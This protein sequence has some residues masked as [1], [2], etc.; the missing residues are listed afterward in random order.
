VVVAA[1]LGLAIVAAASFVVV[2]VV[3]GDTQAL[4]ATLGTALAALAA[5]LGVAGL[6]LVPHEQGEM[7][8]PA[9]DPA[10]PDET[11]EELELP[12]ERVPR[13]R[14]LTAATGA[15]GAAIGVAA[16]TPLASLGPRASASI[17]RSPW[18]RGR[19][20]VDEDGKPL[21]VHE[22]AA[23]DFVTAFP[24]GADPR[25]LGSPVVV[26]RVDPATLQLPAGRESWA[27]EGIL[28]FSKICTHAGCA[29]SLFRYPLYEP[30][31]DAPALVCPCH[32]STFDVRRGAQPI[33]GPAAR[34][35]PQL[36]LAIAAG[37]LVAAG[38]FSGGVGPAWWGL[39]R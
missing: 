21:Q 8:V 36:P 9:P 7:H 18:R 29:I 38:P 11:V 10:L 19:R 6:R 37:E 22:L 16:L 28:A 17:S 1:L 14:L 31:S 27:P 24:A 25:E 12:V 13:R 23:G 34:A 20:L 3:S 2:F 35:L 39:E 15:A 5:A 32:Y 30:T 33:F 4:G 26:V